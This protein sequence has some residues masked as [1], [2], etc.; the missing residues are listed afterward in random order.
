MLNLSLKEFKALAKC[1]GSRDY[2]SMSEDKLL[3][4]L[5]E[6]E[7]LNENEKNFDDRKPKIIFSKPRI[8]KI[9]KLR[10]RFSK[11]K[12]NEIRKNFYEIENKK[13]LL[14]PKIKEIES[15]LELE[16]NLFK[17]KKYYDCTKYKGIRDVKD[18]FDLSVDEDFY[19]PIITNDAFNINYIQYE[20]NGNKHK[21]LT[22]S[23]YFDIIR[24]Y[25]IDIIN[26]HKT[27]GERKIRSG[28]AT[29]E[30]KTRE[31][32]I[33]LTMAINFISGN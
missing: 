8:E 24:P 18:L 33:H 9:R 27:Q 12:I 16:E 28:N 25:L 17:P 7:S 26:D 31:C 15:N 19:K 21:M 2:K 29:T 10:Y 1:R 22:N 20:G 32:K 5:K 4:A 30:H 13:N 3:S 6:S 23:E 14:A 11:S